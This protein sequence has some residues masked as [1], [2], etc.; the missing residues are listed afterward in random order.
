MKGGPFRTVEAQTGPPRPL[1]R[2][3]GDS[4]TA[5]RESRTRV[6]GERTERNRDEMG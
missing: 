1:N 3:C 5:V 4:M 6:N 2:R